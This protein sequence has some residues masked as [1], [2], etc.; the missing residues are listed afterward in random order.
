[1]LV[2]SEL[3][4][5]SAPVDAGKAVVQQ[6]PTA[7]EIWH[8]RL[9]LIKVVCHISIVFCKL[10]VVPHVLHLYHPHTLS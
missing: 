1:M 3:C 6:A 8:E 2:A 4:L 5:Y 9:V 10:H 7:A